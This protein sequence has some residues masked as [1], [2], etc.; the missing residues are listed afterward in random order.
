[1]MFLFI[2]RYRTSQKSTVIAIIH[3]VSLVY[4]VA[5]EVSFGRNENLHSVMRAVS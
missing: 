3:T 5:F 4:V 2:F 1:M